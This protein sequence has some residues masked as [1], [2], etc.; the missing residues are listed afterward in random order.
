MMR[1]SR[2]TARVFKLTLALVALLVLATALLLLAG[3]R[4]RSVDKHDYVAQNEAVLRT[5]PLYPGAKEMTSYSI[6]VSDPN[7]NPLHENGPPYKGFITTHV[8]KLPKSATQTAVLSFYHQRLKLPWLW[9][10]PGQNPGYPPPVEAGFKR[11]EA[12]L[13][14]RAVQGNVSSPAL[15]LLISIN[16]AGNR[17]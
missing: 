8:Y 9:Y 4:V 12:D 13:Y 3:C 10:G 1:W 6:G 2:F 11:G 5:V 14:L 17:K 15:V 16:Y 7:G